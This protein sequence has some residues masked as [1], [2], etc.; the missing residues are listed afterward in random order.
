MSK[1]KRNKE[2]EVTVVEESVEEGQE[3]QS[4]ES[5]VLN[6]AKEVQQMQVNIAKLSTNLEKRS[7]ESG[8]GAGIN[9][10]VLVEN[11]RSSGSY[12]RDR[13][14]I[15]LWKDL[16]GPNLNFYPN[17]NVH[18]VLFL[19]KLSR[20]LH[21]AGVPEDAQVGL[22]VACLKSSAGEWAAY[23]EESFRNFRDFEIAFRERYWGTSQERELY[24]DL[25]YGKYRGGNTRADYVLRLVKQSKFLT[26]PVN[27][28]ELIEWIAKHFSD[29]ADI[30]RSILVRGFT[31]IDEMEKFL[32][33]I[34]IAEEERRT[35]R[36]N[37]NRQYRREDRRADRREENVTVGPSR[38]VVPNEN[39]SGG[40]DNNHTA[41]EIRFLACS[42][43]FMDDVVSS[44][45]ED[46][47]LIL[48]SP[49]ITGTIEN[50]TVDILV[51]SGSQISGIS[52]SFM[53]TLGLNEI[54]TLP[55]ANCSISV[56]V[57]AKS[58]RVKRQIFLTIEVKGHRFEVVLL[59]IPKL[60]T[61]VLLG[62]D[63]LEKVGAI[64]NFGSNTLCIASLGLTIPFK[65]EKKEKLVF[66]NVVG[67]KRRHCYSKE[68]FAAATQKSHNLREKNQTAL[69]NV[70]AEYQD[71]FSETPGR[72]EGYEHE[73]KLR[74]YTPFPRN[75]YPIPVSKREE[76]Q[77]QINDMLAWDIIEAGITEYVSPLVTVNKKDG[78]M[79]VCL[80]ARFINSR[81][82]KDYV[83]PQKPE[84]LLL[85]LGKGRVL[86][87][88]D[89]TASYWQIPIKKEHQ[90]YTG[91]LFNNITYYFK[92]LPFGL[93]TS[94]ASF[95]RALMRVLGPE[96]EA[97]TLTYVDDLLIFSETE[98]EH[99]EHLKIIL[100]KL[101]NANLTVK[102]R[103]SKFARDELEFLGHIISPHGI[104]MDPD[105]ISAINDFPTTRN[106]RELRGFLGLVN[107]DRRFCRNFSD[108][109]LPL[110]NLLK[111]ETP[112]LWGELEEEAFKKIKLAYLQ[113]VMIVHPDF[114]ED[115]FLQCDSSGYAL[116]AYL[117]QVS[118][119]GGQK[120]IAFTS[121]TLRGSELRYTTTEKELLAFIYALKH[122]RSI[123]LG[124]KIN[125]VTDHKAITFLT[126]SKLK[127][128]RFSR[129]V[130][131]MQEF[132]LNI[133]HCAGKE[134]VIADAISRNPAESKTNK[135]DQVE[136][137]EMGML[138]LTKE[139]KLVKTD[140]K[141]IKED[142]RKDNWIDETIGMCLGERKQ[143]KKVERALRCYVLYQDI[144]FRRGD[145]DNP[146]YKLCVPKNQMV[147]LVLQQHHDIGHFGANKT[148]W[149]MKKDFYWPKMRRCIRKLVSTCELCQKTKISPT[150]VGT[151]NSVLVE[152]PGELVCLDLMGP[153]PTS[154]GGTT[155][156]LVVVDAF[157]KYTRLYAL[158]RATAKAILNRLTHDYFVNVQKPRKILSDNGTQFRSKIW[159]ETLIRE[160]IKPKYT[161]VYFPQGNLTERVNRE[162]GRLLRSWCSEK[163][164]K[165]ACVI[166]DVENCINGVVHE[167][168]GSTPNLLQY[169]KSEYNNIRDFLA[170]PN[171]T[172]PAKPIT[173]IW[174]LAK[175]RL[176]NKANLRQKTGRKKPC[177]IFK[178][179]DAVLV[180]THPLSSTEDVKIKKL[181][182]LYEGPYFVSK[183]I[184]PN[185][186]ELIDDAG[187]GRG[188]HNIVN[189][190]RFWKWSHSLASVV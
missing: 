80:D 164:S 150:S 143:D 101:R 62:C 53:Q 1:N 99:I 83:V 35:V 38:R 91:F 5:I 43:D 31:T 7:C 95:I 85:K 177:T 16:G 123:I 75:T 182:K 8:S 33:K 10:S 82:C 105:R 11:R 74:D 59:I 161:S 81:M 166:K 64:L 106:I 21:D 137:V 70:L 118:V 52:E 189:L 23:K 87:S 112:W 46:E 110:S 152:K 134:N 22:A 48:S 188:A 124:Y 133:V 135:M 78:T 151:K 60:N 51:D 122:W 42:T 32:R 18:P 136:H 29:D 131:Y 175:I 63:W 162:I 58:Q 183:V 141:T 116:G 88:L 172:D 84:D 3:S 54:A 129:W 126:A 138:K 89:L 92:V 169:G 44:A 67:Q 120:I 40:A 71:V 41:R 77:R 114:K 190:K 140:L 130:L 149:H 155:Q 173:E 25:K 178:E 6:L 68:E 146:G 24:L 132:D 157:S 127:H 45:E 103:K 30:Q 94:V 184:S 167:S 168:T 15:A 186:Y 19:K 28:S 100:E 27:E 128:A 9:Q 79:R 158:K 55:V 115:F 160:G 109:T 65:W 49:F 187:A 121:R 76:A 72:I 153:L 108:L 163:H 170:Y 14:Y 159:G 142:Q 145:R 96:V 57:G 165:W 61:N 47:A 117:Y 104:K 125:V 56:A 176:R 174:E 39:P 154:R 102:L 107:Y 144:L 50:K 181:F 12:E 17:G 147:N 171:E 139:Y 73:I 36:V 2:L 98:E 86:S 90:K 20:L 26:E 179:G 34:D 113:E 97:F 93:V 13:S 4:L 37:E 119:Q 69:N 66:V 185:S 111:K 148:Y 180:K 156:L